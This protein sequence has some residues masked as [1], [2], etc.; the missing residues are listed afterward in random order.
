MFTVSELLHAA[1]EAYMP[2]FKGLA[3]L[4]GASRVISEYAKE[5]HQAA[6]GFVILKL[7]NHEARIARIE[8]A[9]AKAEQPKREIGTIETLDFARPQAQLETEGPPLWQNRAKNR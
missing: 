3:G 1:Q 8:A 5:W 4:H 2:A 6:L 9:L 7:R